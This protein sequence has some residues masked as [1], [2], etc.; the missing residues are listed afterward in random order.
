MLSQR[1]CA[2]LEGNSPGEAPGP[3]KGSAS[4]HTTA[5]P[6]FLHFREPERVWVL[7]SESPGLA[8]LVYYLPAV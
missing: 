6:S 5:P 1:T 8:S 4:A 2:R 3:R 7:A